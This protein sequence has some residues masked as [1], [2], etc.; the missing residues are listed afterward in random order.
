[1][2]ATIDDIIERLGGPEAAA[3]LTAVSTEAVRKWRQTGFVPS[4]HWAA[5]S[6]ATGLTMDEL[7]GEIPA[8]PG[9][10]PPGATAALVLADGSVFWGRGFGAHTGQSAPVGEICFN[11]GMKG[12]R[13]R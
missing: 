5:V 8:P 11:T 1:M 3:R 7:R 10:I 13:K 4:R 9:D 2:P 6:A 12:I